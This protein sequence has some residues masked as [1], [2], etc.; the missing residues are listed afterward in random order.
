MAGTKVNIKT[1]WGKKE[2]TSSIKVTAKTL[3]GA[4]D[5]LSK[6]NEWGKFD[7]KIDYDYKANAD[8]YLT[9]VILKPSYTIH[10]PTWASYGKSPEACQKEWDRMWKKLEEHEEGHRQIHLESLATIQ[11]NLQGQTDLTVDQFEADFAQWMQAGQDDQAKFDTSTAN[12]KN[13][14]VELNI[15]SECE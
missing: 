12:G 6:R 7:W 4:L 8:N 1:A 5:E 9:E 10:M 14:G 15:M 2:K 11:R 13:K 3:G